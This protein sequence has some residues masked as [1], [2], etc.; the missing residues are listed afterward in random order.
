VLI[1]QQSGKSITSPASPLGFKPFPKRTN[2]LPNA[3]TWRK[4]TFKL[5]PSRFRKNPP[6]EFDAWQTVVPRAFQQIQ[7]FI[8]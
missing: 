4:I 5:Q 7:H 1:K 6:K 2:L 8:E 3:P